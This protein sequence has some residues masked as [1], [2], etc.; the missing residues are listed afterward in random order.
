M[1]EGT[2]F[3]E[4]YGEDGKWEE[5]LP[6]EEEE[7]NM[8]RKTEEMLQRA[9]YHRYEISNYAKRG[10]EC[11]HN[12]G[13]W[14]RTEYLGLGLGAS[15]FLNQTRFHNTEDMERYLK[16]AKEHENIHEEIEHLK[17]QE[18]MEEFIFLGLRKMKGI[19]ETE[20]DEAF[21]T[22]I[23]ECYGKN[24]RRVIQNGLLEQEN[25]Y[26]RLTKK[27]IDVSNYVFAEILSED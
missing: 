8:Y 1:E 2:P 12:L 23:W 18:Q 9:G 15:S 17:V 19:A 7:R 22:D 4:L 5:M 27:G 11:R 6:D 3:A 25:G 10:Y 16:N 13:Y 14:D 26:L 20:F 24:I 21:G